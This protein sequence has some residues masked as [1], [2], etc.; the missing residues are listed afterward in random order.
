MLEWLIMSPDSCQPELPQP[1]R[2]PAEL[3]EHRYRSI[4]VFSASSDTLAPAFFQ[5]AEELAAWM[6][7]RKIALVFGAGNIGLMGRMAEVMHENGGRVVGVIPEMLHLKGYSYGKC[8]ELIVTADMRNRKFEMEERADAFVALPGGF[9]TL[10]ELLEVITL[11]Q[12]RSKWTSD[13]DVAVYR[14]YI[15]A[16]AGGR[17]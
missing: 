9:G 6:A 1:K 7:R 2:F 4:C 5:A 17:S 12:S 11:K 13:V 3:T 15:T 8:D 16:T 10:E 14:Q